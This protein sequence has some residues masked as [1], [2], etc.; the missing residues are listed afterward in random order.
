MTE[1]RTRYLDRIDDRIDRLVLAENGFLYVVTKRFESRAFVSDNRL[2]R[3][4]CHARDRVLDHLDR[5]F[6]WTAARGQQLDRSAD[7]V[8]DINGLVGQKSVVYIFT[9]ELG[10]S[11]KRLVA[12]F[13]A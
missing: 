3:Y 12:V 8:D 13:D 5:N 11:T 2:W 1:A 10:R 9:G 7:L 4:L 6:F